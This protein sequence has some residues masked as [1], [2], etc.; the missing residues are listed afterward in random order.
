M[1]QYHV[2]IA[3]QLQEDLPGPPDINV[4]FLQVRRRNVLHSAYMRIVRGGEVFPAEQVVRDETCDGDAGD[5]A[6]TAE[7]AE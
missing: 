4:E 2:A 7:M 5:A 1:Q 3:I 6:D